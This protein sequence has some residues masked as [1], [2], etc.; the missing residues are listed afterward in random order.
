MLFSVMAVPITL[1]PKRLKDFLPFLH[2]LTTLSFFFFFP[3]NSHPK[4][5]EVT[6]QC[7]LIYPLCFIMLSAFLY[8]CWPLYIFFGE[9]STQNLYPFLIWLFKVVFFLAI[10]KLIPYQKHHLQIFSPIPYVAFSFC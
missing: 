10:W 5:C 9:I 8:T 3:T 6:S 2:I 4:Q 1:L 7:V